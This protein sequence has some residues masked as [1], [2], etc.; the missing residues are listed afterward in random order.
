M[1]LQ[2]IGWIL[3]QIQ[4]TLEFHTFDSLDSPW[5]QKAIDE[6]MEGPSGV[7]ASYLAPLSSSPCGQLSENESGK[8]TVL[9]G[10]NM[11]HSGPG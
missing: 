1:A 3:H 5:R 8:E 2:M 10:S 6:S 11:W 9:F 7:F 4:R